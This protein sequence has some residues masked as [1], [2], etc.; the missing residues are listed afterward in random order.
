[1]KGKIAILLLLFALLFAGCVTKNDDTTPQEQTGNQE[2]Q[3]E[4]GEQGT[5]GQNNIVPEEPFIELDEECVNACN[6]ECRIESEIKC[7]ESCTQNVPEACSAETEELCFESCAL[8]GAS[9][10]ACEEG[11]TR[12]QAECEGLVMA[13]C[14][15]GCVPEMLSPDLDCLDACVQK[16]A[17]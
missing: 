17:E 5:S 10:L 2:N 9:N 15:S 7:N 12:E 4:T 13:D 8:S 11:C 6:D 3:P 1:M 16:C 14:I